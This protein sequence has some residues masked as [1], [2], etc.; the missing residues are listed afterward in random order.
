MRLTLVHPAVGRRAGVDYMRTWQMEPL[1][2][3]LLAALTPKDV[4]I[5][6]HDD[7]M[8]PIPFDR[9]A[10]LVAI[11]VETY[12]PSAPIRSPASIAAAACRW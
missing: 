9:P 2:I 1:T 6:F 5:T 8:E 11:P 3:A 10:D 4:A 7:R 12:R